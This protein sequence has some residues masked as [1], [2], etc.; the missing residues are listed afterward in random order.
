LCAS[1]LYSGMGAADSADL[2]F[3]ATQ[4]KA[5]DFTQ[6]RRAYLTRRIA[7]FADN[8]RSVMAMRQT[9]NSRLETVLSSLA[10][11]SNTSR[12]AGSARRTLRHRLIVTTTIA[13]ESENPDDEVETT[14]D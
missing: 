12:G 13:T 5:I 2:K 6:G 3:I 4:L 1:K 14:E 8:A 11:L 9:A 10:T 7:V